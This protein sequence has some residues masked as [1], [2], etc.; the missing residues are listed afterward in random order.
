M[1]YF[2]A[3]TFKFCSWQKSI[4]ELSPFLQ[5]P[6]C[7]FDPDWEIKVWRA[8]KSL[9]KSTDETEGLEEA[10]RQH[11]HNV[12]LE[13]RFNRLQDVWAK[14]QTD[15]LISFRS[16]VV[17]SVGKSN[18]RGVWIRFSSYYAVLEWMTYW[19][20]VYQPGTVRVVNL[21]GHNQQTQHMA[22][23]QIHSRCWQEQ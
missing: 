9:I 15:W 4:K 3:M 21:E 7:I 18:L 19:A 2:I 12:H 1:Q 17:L 8:G 14:L 20:L 11:S 10:S 5:P 13:E 16:L 6:Q 22:W 23:S